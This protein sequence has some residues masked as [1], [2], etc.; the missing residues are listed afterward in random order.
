MWLSWLQT[1]GCNPVNL[2]WFIHLGWKIHLPSASL[3]WHQQNLFL[4][5]WGSAMPPKKEPVWYFS[6]CKRR[7]KKTQKLNNQESG[8]LRFSN[9]SWILFTTLNISRALP[10]WAHVVGMK[11]V[12]GKTMLIPRCLLARSA[13]MIC[14]CTLLT[15]VSKSVV[16]H[17]GCQMALSWGWV[18]SDKICRRS[19]RNGEKKVCSRKDV[20][21]EL[22]IR[23][24]EK[25][26]KRERI[27][28]TAWGGFGFGLLNDA[29]SSQ[30]SQER[31]ILPELLCSSSFPSL[32]LPPRLSFN[33]FQLPDFSVSFSTF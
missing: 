8:K 7:I 3:H 29:R 28:L 9:L 22:Q 1:C 2:S 5:G 23:E 26:R 4:S 33:D 21:W 31:R 27:S 32:R 24:E 20:E 25:E 14:G 18:W 30:A 13:W 17:P 12:I 16:A 10:G 19:G 15:G 6:T 11:V